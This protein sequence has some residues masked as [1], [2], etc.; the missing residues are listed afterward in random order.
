MNQQAHIRIVQWSK[1]HSLTSECAK[2][3]ETEVQPALVAP[4]NT[5]PRPYARMGDGYF[6]IV[7]TTSL[8]NRR[9]GDFPTL[10]RETASCHTVRRN[11]AG[12]ASAG[13][14]GKAREDR[15]THRPEKEN[16]SALTA[17]NRGPE[18]GDASG[19]CPWKGFAPLTGNMCADCQYSEHCGFP[20][21]FD[22]F[23]PGPKRGVPG[24]FLIFV[25]SFYFTH[26]P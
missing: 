24:G 2:T 21:F 12:P 23:N 18:A 19:S 1:Q 6:W 4:L 7:S 14:R 17:G 3:L 15:N 5:S 20:F 13:A 16:V 11:M 10:N 25:L 8:R 22:R 9:G 26:F